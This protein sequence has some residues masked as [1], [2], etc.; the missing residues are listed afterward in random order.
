MPIRERKRAGGL[1]FLLATPVKRQR[2]KQITR[3]GCRNQ[4]IHQFHFLSL[5]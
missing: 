1:S 2:R 5:D 3:Q 4:S